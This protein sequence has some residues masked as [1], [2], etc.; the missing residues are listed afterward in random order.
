LT[1]EAPDP[2]AFPAIGLAY[3]AARLGGAAPAWLSAANEVA[4][5]A[6]LADEIGWCDIVDVVARVMDGYVTD[7]LDSLGDLVASDATARRRA[8]GIL[9][10]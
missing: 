6:F 10:Q 8:H 5:A 1:F 7:P 3:E 9:K 4:V 2:K